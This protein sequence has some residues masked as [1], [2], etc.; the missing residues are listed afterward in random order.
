MNREEREIKNMKVQDIQEELLRYIQ[1]YKEHLA[2]EGKL[3]DVYQSTLVAYNDARRLGEPNSE[4][5][6][7]QDELLR[8][9]DKRIDMRR[10][11][12]GLRGDIQNL[13]NY[14]DYTIGEEKQ[15]YDT[16]IPSRKELFPPEFGFTKRARK[17][18]R[19]SRKVVR[20]V[21]KS[22]RKSRKVVRKSVRKPARSSRKQ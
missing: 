16:P 7:L 13:E 11:G 8:L 18:A 3:N 14:L 10:E 22:V 12:D 21:R 5:I 9:R 1:Y 6:T 4:I 20:K 19:G 15:K 2:K 17:G